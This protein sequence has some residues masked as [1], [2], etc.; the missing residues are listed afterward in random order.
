MATPPLPTITAKDL[1]EDSFHPIARD[2]AAFIEVQIHLQKA[3]A[4][5]AAR[6][7]QAFSAATSTLAQ[8]ARER[9]ATAMAHE[10]DRRRLE[11]VSP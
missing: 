4:A 9:A 1:L 3:L 11:A 5:V 8:E 7:P 2:G 6:N 10:A